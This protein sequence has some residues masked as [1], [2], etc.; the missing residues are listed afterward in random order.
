M[1]GIVQPFG[2]GE[3]MSIAGWVTSC[4]RYPGKSECFASIAVAL[5]SSGVMRINF[6]SKLSNDGMIGSTGLFT[7]SRSFAN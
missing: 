4:T 7:G 5:E 6:T 3:R 1:D 2:G